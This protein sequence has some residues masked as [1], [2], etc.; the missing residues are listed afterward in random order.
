MGA[1]LTDQ[2]KGAVQARLD[3]LV[4]LTADLTRF[5]STRGNEAP[6]QN[7]VASQLIQ[8]G[9]EV[10]QWEIDVDAISS[11]KGFSPVTVDYDGATNVVGTWRSRQQSGRSLILNGHVDVVP[12]GPLDMWD[13]PPYE[14]RITDGWMYGRGTGDM[15]AGVAAMIVALDALADIGY[16]PAADVFLQSVIEEECTGNGALACIERGYHADAAIIPEPF[17]EQ[18][19]SAQVGVIWFKIRVTGVPVH[20]ASAGTGSNAIE[21]VWPLIAALHEL[22]AEWNSD[23]RRNPHFADVEHP[24]NLNVG[25]IQGGDWASSVPAWC[26]I[27][28]R[29]GIFGGQSIEEAMTE[30]EECVASAAKT[31]PMLSSQHPKLTFNGFLAEGYA[32]ADDG[33]EAAAAAIDTLAR[34]HLEV[35]GSSLLQTPTTA[36]TDARFFGLYDGTPALVYGPVAERIHGFNEAVEI[37]SVRRIC[38]SIALFVADWC[39]LEPHP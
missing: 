19:I 30:I 22:E 2:I 7:F 10:D 20:V 11:M 5:G 16:R 6:V 21:A 12:E 29:M 24:L 32:L 25:K 34:A 13:T 15:K 3:D 23:E 37:E 1:E 9:Y 18:L 33:G 27:D 14:P 31:H 17:A 36:T 28:C 39:G 26:E 4:E 35:A 8:R 38:A